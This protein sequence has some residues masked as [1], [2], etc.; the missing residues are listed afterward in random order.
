MSQTASK[1]IAWSRVD[2]CHIKI[3]TTLA[4]RDRDYVSVMVNRVSSFE[5]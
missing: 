4:C 3:V 1:T 5:Y 2:Q